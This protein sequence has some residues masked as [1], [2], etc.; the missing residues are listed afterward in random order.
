MAIDWHIPNGGTFDAVMSLTVPTGAPARTWAPDAAKFEGAMPIEHCI[1]APVQTML[2]IRG[3]QFGDGRRPAS[4]RGCAE[5]V[6]IE[7][8]MR[9]QH[10]PGPLA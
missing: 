10:P 4:D 9:N 3:P 6:G 5:Y 2:G 7:P 8:T 1:A